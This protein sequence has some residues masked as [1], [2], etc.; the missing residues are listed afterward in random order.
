MLQ[1]RENEGDDSFSIMLFPKYIRSLSLL[2]LLLLLLPL[3]QN[4]IIFSL[5]QASSQR[6]H[7]TH[8]Q[9]LFN[10][11]KLVLIIISTSSS[12]A[13]VFLLWHRS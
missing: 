10:S 1:R 12:F 3:C 6:S 2:L 4:M 8:S 11:L 7:V 9:R 13:L 5:L